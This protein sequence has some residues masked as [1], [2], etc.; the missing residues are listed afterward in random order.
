MVLKGVVPALLGTALLL[1][2]SAGWAAD[3]RPDEFL[4]LDLSKAVLSPKR[5]GP[6]TEFAPVPVEAKNEA[7]NEVKSEPSGIVAQNANPKKVAVEHVEAAPVRAQ[8]KTPHRHSRVAQA[9]SEK[10][11]GTGRVHL[12]R[13]HGNPMNAQAM[14]TRIQ[15]WPCN[16]DYGGIC[17]WRR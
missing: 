3:Y 15:K 17:A 2:G 13:R 6:P 1:G 10:R 12:A 5:L 14:D 16:P 9:R 11:R 7:K 4:N 8:L